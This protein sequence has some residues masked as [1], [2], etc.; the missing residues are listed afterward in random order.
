MRCVLLEKDK[1][2][3]EQ[4]LECVDRCQCCLL[5]VR[6]AASFIGMVAAWLDCSE[7]LLVAKESSV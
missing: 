2:I 6:S 7:V 3:G 5:T 4:E 1:S